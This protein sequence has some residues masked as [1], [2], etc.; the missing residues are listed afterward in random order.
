MAD[1]LILDSEA[2]IAA[3][4]KEKQVFPQSA[5]LIVEDLR[6]VK[7]SAE[8]YVNMIYRVRGS[9]GHS[10]VVKQITD[11]PLSR[12]KEM[13]GDGEGQDSHAPI[14]KDDWTLDPGRL[15]TEISVLIF[16]NRIKPGICPEIYHFSEDNG[17]IVMEDLSDLSLLRYEFGRMV[18]YPGIGKTMGDFC[19]RNLFYSSDLNMTGYRHQKL[20]DFFDNPEYTAL[21]QFIYHECCIVSDSRE[22]PAQVNP[23]R[24]RILANEAVQKRIGEMANSCLRKKEC[25]IHTDIH[26][27][28][29]MVGG[30]DVK[31]I[32]TEFAGFGPA[33]QD[34]GR[35]TASFI[36]N[37]VSWY[38]D[39]GVHT[40]TE[41]ADFRVYLLDMIADLYHT[42]DDTFRKLVDEN[43][44]NNY[45]LK[46][47]DVDAFLAGLHADCFDATSL[48]AAS[49]IA[50][51]GLCHDLERLPLEER[52]YPQHLILTI[53]EE[54]LGGVVELTTVDD[55]VTY[56]KGVAGRHPKESYGL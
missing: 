47:F 8:G 48:N 56:L 42:F 35:F 31:I 9:N 30:D 24:M 21:Y 29:I 55:Y 11:V 12:A 32:D 6:S 1:K 52:Y 7:E 43:K 40:E 34:F 46:R 13:A 28:N 36:L 26:A 16:W 27:S 5:E 22:M 51:R 3:Y 20:L 2:A 15:R 33:A 19:A 44:A 50:D 23:H 37:Y 49:R 4:L 54:I 38:A 45:N 53:A 41:K 17:I 10:V 39:D 14:E 25:L 18:R